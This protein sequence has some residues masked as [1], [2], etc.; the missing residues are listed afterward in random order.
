MAGH[1]ILE[2]TADVGVRAWAETLEECFEQATWGLAEIIGIA[3]PGRGES[4]H[5]ALEA[6]DAGA[7]LVDWLNEVLYLHDTHDAAIGRVRVASVTEEHVAGTVDLIPRGADPS[8]GTQV[9]AVTYHQLRVERR[10]EGFVAQVY[11][12]V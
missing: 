2:H 6:S 12:D 1:E 8:E 3:R 7:L 5:I 10:A 11:F 9:K 4:T